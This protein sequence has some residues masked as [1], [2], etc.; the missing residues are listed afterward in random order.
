MICRHGLCDCS[1]N[2]KY[3]KP[4]EQ[5]RGKCYRKASRMYDSCEQDEQCFGVS[6]KAVCS[7]NN[8]LCVCRLGYYNLNEECIR[9]E[10]FE[11][12]KAQQVYRTAMIAAACFMIGIVSIFVVCIVKKSFC[13]DD[14]RSTLPGGQLRSNSQLQRM[15]SLTE[16]GI[17]VV[18]K[19]PSYEEIILAEIPTTP[20]PKYTD[21][22]KLFPITEGLQ[23]HSSEPH[24]NIPYLESGHNRSNSFHAYDNLAASNDANNIEIASTPP[25]KYEE[26]PSSKPRPNLHLNIPSITISVDSPTDETTVQH[27]T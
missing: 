27:Q 7:R 18:D 13:G 25:P 20:P 6:N 21:I 4:T 23:R 3:I 15:T 5:E 11:R 16:D 9:Q 1:I 8:N 12:S 19:P 17:I 2:Y 24:L 10:E 22:S 26:C 14:N